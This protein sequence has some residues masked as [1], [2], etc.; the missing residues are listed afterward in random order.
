MS[1]DVKHC[2]AMVRVKTRSRHPGVRDTYV[3]ARCGRTPVEIHH[4]LTRARGGL[5]LDEVGE[6]YHLIALCRKCHSLAHTQEYS[7]NG[8]LMIDGYV[9]T[10]KGRPN[11]SGPDEYLRRKYGST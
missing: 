4:R 11:Y 9:N 7:T 2:E 3:W 5:I 1:Y 8:G 10:I 6:T